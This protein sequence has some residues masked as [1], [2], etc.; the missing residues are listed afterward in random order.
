M[1]ASSTPG[2]ANRLE[3]RGLEPAAVDE[4]AEAFRDWPKDR[5]LFERYAA[6]QAGGQRDVVVAR[7]DDRPVG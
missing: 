2:T 3:L 1:P 7:L 6:M 4:L 5:E